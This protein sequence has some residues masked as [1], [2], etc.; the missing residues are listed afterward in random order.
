MRSLSMSMI[1]A[2]CRSSN[3]AAGGVATPADA[4]L[5]MQLGAEGVFVGSGIFKSGNPAKRA[6]AIVQAVTNYEDPK[7]HRRTFRRPWRGDGRH[8]M[9]RKLSF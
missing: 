6:R 5:M 3:F 8:Q 2:G 1:T 7:N 4:A 9:K